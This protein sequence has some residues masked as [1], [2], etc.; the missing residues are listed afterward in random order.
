MT[1]PRANYFQG[2]NPLRAFAA[3]SVLAFHVAG[4]EGWSHVPTHGPL[5]WIRVGWVGLDV[6]FVISGLVVGQSALAGFQALGPDF[7]SKFITHRLVRIAPLYILAGSVWVLAVNA[8]LIFGEGGAWQVLT[9]LFFIHNLW[10][11]TS[12]SINPPSWS[13]GLEIQ[14]Y[15]V[16]LVATPWLCRQSA[17]R[18]ALLSALFALAYRSCAYF[19]AKALGAD[20]S[21]I[22]QHAVYQTPGMIDAFG[23]GVAIAIAAANNRLPQVGPV[24]RTVLV[25]AG[26]F[27]LSMV[28]LATPQ[29][30]DGSIWQQPLLALTIRSMVAIAAVALVLGCTLQPAGTDSRIGAMFKHW[31]DLSYGI[32]LWHSFVLYEVVRYTRLGGW[33]LLAAVLIT[34]IVLAEITWRTVERPI[35]RRIMKRR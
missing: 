35:L 16:L 10:M 24:G 21:G 13:L 11:N 26:L 8:G 18:V 34:T 33:P 27:G 1:V 28:S 30:I 32:Y 14:L 19:V 15:V 25:G 5:A 17:M 12:G 4:L 2:L 20:T 29:M 6:F 31:G 9:H 23:F 22:L 7:R 3:L